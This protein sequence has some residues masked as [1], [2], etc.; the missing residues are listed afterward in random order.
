MG[1]PKPAARLPPAAVA[2]AV[3]WSY[4]HTS[5]W[6]LTTGPGEW[7]GSAVAT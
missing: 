1:W 7:M 5:D 2:I 3:F 6:Y 4:W